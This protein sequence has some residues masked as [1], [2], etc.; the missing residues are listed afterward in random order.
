MNQTDP[1]III[2]TDIIPELK[3]Q[4][5]A[6]LQKPTLFSESVLDFYIRELHEQHSVNLTIF[7]PS[8]HPMEFSLF[9]GPE[10]FANF[11]VLV[12]VLTRYFGY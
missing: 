1:S 5:I 11:S 6:Y 8:D 4:A 9:L 10:E 3:M 12:E 7:N 2:E